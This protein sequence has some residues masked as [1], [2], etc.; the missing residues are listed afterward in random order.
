MPNHVSNTI[1]FECDEKRLKEI[2]DAI[3]FESDAEVEHTGIGTLDFNKIIPMPKSLEIEAGS[4]TDRGLKAYQDFISVYTLGGTINTDMLDNIPPESENIFLRQR[5]DI[6]RSDFE[7]GKIAWNNLR[8]Y[9]SST[10]YEWSISKWG[11]KWN[12]YDYG[13]YDG[14]NSIT[15]NTAWSAPHPILQ[16][17]SEMFPE[18]SITHRWADED[19]GNNCGEME[20]EGG[21]IIG[22]DIPESCSKEAYDLAFAQWDYD[23]AEEGFVLSADGSKWLYAENEDYELIEFCG[24]PALFTN[25]RL[26]DSKIPEGLH[27]YHL[28]ESDDGDHFCSVEPKVG[29]N[30]GGSVIVNEP[31]DFG[32]QGYIALSDETSPNFLGEHLSFRQFMDG[33][34]EQN[35]G[36]KLE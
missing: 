36:M 11:T 10:W 18:V 29:V 25:E 30:H 34:F 33:D 21:D 19:L 1:T 20:Y 6:K 32:E 8:E 3:K 14:G 26:D 16:K 12:S 15:F 4:S 9:G 27:C 31:I 7:L 23:P 22:E 17:L 24:Q 13:D 2:L 35:G 28:R 5:T